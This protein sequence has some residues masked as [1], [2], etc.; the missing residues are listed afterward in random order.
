MLI[1]RHL[2]AVSQLAMD[3]AVCRAMY[4]LLQPLKQVPWIRLTVYSFKGFRLPLHP[5]SLLSSYGR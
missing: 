2:I 1:R 5:A 4:S 3:A